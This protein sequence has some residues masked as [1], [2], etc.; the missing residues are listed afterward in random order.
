MARIHHY[1]DLYEGKE[2]TKN[3]R[4]RHM[5]LGKNIRG[6][7]RNN[8]A[9]RRTMNLLSPF[10]CNRR[11]DDIQNKNFLNT[12]CDNDEGH[13]GIENGNIIL[14]G[15]TGHQDNHEYGHGEY[16]G[17]AYPSYYAPMGGVGYGHGVRGQ[18]DFIEYQGPSGYGGGGGYGGY[19]GGYGYQR[20]LQLLRIIKEDEPEGIFDTLLSFFD[21][22]F[23]PFILLLGLAGIGAAA[24]LFSAITNAGKRS[25]KTNL[26]KGGDWVGRISHQQQNHLQELHENVIKGKYDNYAYKVISIYCF[27]NQKI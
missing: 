2:R 10:L 27:R 26:L 20:P 13:N 1:Y 16:G 18:Q 7:R 19:G 21:I 11:K 12:F 15:D 14:Y 25:L 17:Q 3:K 6:Q 24:V 23:E 22:G 4:K 8:T 5:S 9:N